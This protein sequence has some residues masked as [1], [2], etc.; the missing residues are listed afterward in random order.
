MSRLQY[1]F[2]IF[3]TQAADQ[4]ELRTCESTHN[5][6]RI[7][8]PHVLKVNSLASIFKKTCICKKK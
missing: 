6:I 1:I 2:L 7:S 4:S 5:V 3:C 8:D